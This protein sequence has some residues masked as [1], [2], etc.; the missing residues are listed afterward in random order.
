M[1]VKETH[2]F[3]KTPIFHQPNRSDRFRSLVHLTRALRGQGREGHECDVAVE[4]E[5]TGVGMPGSLIATHG[6]LKTK[7]LPN[8]KVGVPAHV[9]GFFG[10]V[11]HRCFFVIHK[12]VY[13]YISS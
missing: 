4:R 2:H 8:K 10:F 11:I 6:G 9:L 1:V 3:R 7:H 12:N 5:P 13:P